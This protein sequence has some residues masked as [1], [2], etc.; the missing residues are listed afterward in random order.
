MKSRGGKKREK[1]CALAGNRGWLSRVGSEC[2]T[3]EPPMLLPVRV[4][5]SSP[6]SISRATEEPGAAR[7]KSSKIG[8][9]LRLW[10]TELTD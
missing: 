8:L 6:E 3:T 5:D 2:S 1:H 4:S 7:Q 10:K 9:P